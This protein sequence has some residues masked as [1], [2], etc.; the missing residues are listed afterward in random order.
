MEIYDTYLNIEW[1]NKIFKQLDVSKINHIENNLNQELLQ[2]DI[3]PPLPLVFNALNLTSLNNTK[4][5]IIGQDPYHNINQAHGLSFS[6]KDEVKIPPSLKNI[7]KEIESDLNIKMSDSGNLTSWAKQGVLLLNSIL[8]VRAHE[9]ASHKNIGWEY[10]TDEI[11]KLI[12]L[13]KENVVFLLWGK[14][15]Q[16]KA[17][18]IDSNKHL[19]LQAAHPSPFS[20]YRGF[21]GC[22]HF[23]LSNEYLKKHQKAI[24]DW[25]I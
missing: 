10:F 20:V 21:Y 14:F 19:I 6:V 2:F 16:A 22:K 12:S 5:V 18:L 15:A 13:E 23:S 9:P 8:T 1:K 17:H 11:I 7:C 24:I 3:F 4:I 25:T